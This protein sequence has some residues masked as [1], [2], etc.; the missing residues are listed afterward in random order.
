MEDKQ[1]ICKIRSHDDRIKTKKKGILKVLKQFHIEL[2]RKGMTADHNIAM[3]RIINLA[4]HS[5]SRK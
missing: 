4:E 1:Q 5:V 2:F 3:A